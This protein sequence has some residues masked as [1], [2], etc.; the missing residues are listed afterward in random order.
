V[1]HFFTGQHEDY[2][3]PGDD[4]EKLNYAGMEKIAAYIFNIINDLNDNGQL[5]FRKTKNESEDV[6][7]FEVALGVVPDYLYTGPGMR[8]DG[9]SEDKPAQRAGLQKGDI[10]QQLGSLQVTDMMSYMKALASFEEGQSTEVTVD[11]NGE[12]LVVSVTF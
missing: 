5:A 8:I 7:R 3:K 4:A 10:V 2:H 9:V 11:R 6:P 1:L 12:T